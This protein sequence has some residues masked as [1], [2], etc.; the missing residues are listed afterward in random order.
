[1]LAKKNRNPRSQIDSIL[2]QGRKVSSPYFFLICKTS[3]SLNNPQIS[4]TVSKKTAPK[5]VD[6]NKLRRQIYN[7]VRFFIKKIKPST[8]MVFIV[9]KEAKELSF[10]S[11]SDEI[12]S[13]CVKAGII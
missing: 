11:L 12:L 8:A 7:S 5:A 3:N 2:R 4:V 10:Q 13:I 9:K 6:R 1:M